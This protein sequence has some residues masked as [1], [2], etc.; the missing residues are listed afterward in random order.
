MKS[1]ANATVNVGET[2]IVKGEEKRVR[3]QK[4]LNDM[5]NMV[6]KTKQGGGMRANKAGHTSEEE[7]PA[8]SGTAGAGAAPSTAALPCS[9]AARRVQ[10]VSCTVRTTCNAAQRTTT[11]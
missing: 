7:Q 4:H 1:F 10:L 5:H 8:G 11:Q 2:K 6:P 3:L 9:R